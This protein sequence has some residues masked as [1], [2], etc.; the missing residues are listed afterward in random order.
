MTKA[1]IERMD[2]RRHAADVAGLL[3]QLGTDE[4]ILDRAAVRA[5]RRKLA[6]R[7]IAWCPSPERLAQWLVSVR[8][9][10]GAKNLAGYLRAAVDNG[11]DPGTLLGSHL[12]NV[13]GQGAE[14]FQ[15]FT[16]ATEQALEG[17]RAQDVAAIVDATGDAMRLDDMGARAAMRNQLWE[18]LAKGRNA[19]ARQV[20][21]QLVGDD[22]SDLAVARAIGDVCTLDVARE[23]LAA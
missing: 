6:T 2:D 9:E 23:L 22:R 1:G 16:T 21:L 13:Y 12:R 5:D 3:D 11:G 18:M 19:T 15:H 20:L 14:Q 10:F 7:A 4:D 17:E 8:R